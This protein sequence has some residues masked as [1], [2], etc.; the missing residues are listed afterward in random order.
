MDQGIHDIR[1]YLHTDSLSTTED[2]TATH[3]TTVRHLT[4]RVDDLDRHKINSC[5]AV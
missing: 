4:C 3:T 1:V 5:G 2:M